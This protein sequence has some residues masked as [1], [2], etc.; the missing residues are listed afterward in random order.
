MISK[1]LR[2]EVKGTMGRILHLFAS[3]VFMRNRHHYHWHV[4]ADRISLRVYL[5][6]VE[7][8]LVAHRDGF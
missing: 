2:R 8:I 3:F 6:I 7:G 1:N 5:G 4:G